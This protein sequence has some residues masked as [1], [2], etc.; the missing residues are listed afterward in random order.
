MLFPPVPLPAVKSPPA[1]LLQPIQQSEFAAVAS[2]ALGTNAE[3][4]GMVHMTGSM[5]HT[6]TGRDGQI[7]CTAHHPIMALTT[8]FDGALW[9]TCMHT[10]RHT[11]VCLG[12]H[13]V[14]QPR[15]VN[16]ET[17]GVHTAY[18]AH[19]CTLTCVCTD[20]H[21]DRQRSQSS[22]RLLRHVIGSGLYACCL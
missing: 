17:E 6:C 1:E 11:Q 15:H 10:V 13:A 12:V 20:W 14:N 8:R 3:T 18:M 21:H 5:P 16:E 22:S 7:S 9:A 2:S 4:C 19:S